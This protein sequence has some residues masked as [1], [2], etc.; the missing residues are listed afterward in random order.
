[1][2]AAAAQL[3]ERC[4]VALLD[5]SSLGCAAVPKLV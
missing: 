2:G 4:T 5:A 3:A 1:L